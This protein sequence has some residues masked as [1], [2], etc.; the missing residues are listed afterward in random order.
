[1]TKHGDHFNRN[2]LASAYLKLAVFNLLDCKK[3][4]SQVMRS[5]GRAPGLRN[6]GLLLILLLPTTRL[7]RSALN[8][9]L[10]AMRYPKSFAGRAA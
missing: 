7:S 5:I 2:E 1:M 9:V 3:R 8:L 6:L 4:F 10:D